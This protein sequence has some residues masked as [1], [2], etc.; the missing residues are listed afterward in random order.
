MIYLNQQKT[1]YMI[2]EE[3]DIR[4]KKREKIH[5]IYQTIIHYFLK[6]L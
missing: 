2:V 4:K 3:K 5:K 6:N 1:I